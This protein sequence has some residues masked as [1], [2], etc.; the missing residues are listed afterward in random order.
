MTK[1]TLVGPGPDEKINPPGNCIDKPAEYK[2][3]G[4]VTFPKNRK[5]T[6]LSPLVEAYHV[7]KK[8]LV[9][10]VVFVA[11]EELEDLKIS[12]FQNCYVNIEGDAQLQFFIAYDLK[13]TEGVDFYIYEVSFEADDIPFKGGLG[14]IDTIQ[15]F[16][17]DI[18]PISSRGTETNVQPGTGTEVG[19]H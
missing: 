15:T 9:R 3:R 11:H 10:A 14:T 2:R 4:H 19:G 1:T 16:L 13:P 6:L 12:V 7:G 17:W 8:L 5:K 18:D